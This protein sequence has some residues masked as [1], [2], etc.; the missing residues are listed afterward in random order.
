MGAITSSLIFYRRLLARDFVYGP[1][2]GIIAGGVSSYFTANLAMSL[3]AGL[4]GGSLQATLLNALE[5]VNYQ[6]A[7]QTSFIS[8]N[9]FGIQGFLACILG[10]IAK[11]II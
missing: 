5:K 3:I 9:L 6:N 8:F 4:I 2:S 7:K 1:L 10:C 11:A